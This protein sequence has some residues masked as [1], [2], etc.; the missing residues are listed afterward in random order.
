MATV[1]KENNIGKYK[2]LK[3]DHALPTKPYTKYVI[4]GTVYDIV[5]IYDAT[6]CITIVGS[7][8]FI[9]KTV[10]FK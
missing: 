10:E 6:N 4:D 7:G 5:P 8:S 3:L 2:T 9:G 1:I